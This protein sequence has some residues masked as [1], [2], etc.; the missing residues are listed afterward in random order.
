[1]AVHNSCWSPG[2]MYPSDLT[3]CKNLVC[4]IDTIE[5]VK[6]AGVSAVPFH[7]LMRR[8]IDSRSVFGVCFGSVRSC[9]HTILSYRSV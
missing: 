6:W 1:M 3:D 8:R 5:R 9:F 7:G 4:V 2:F